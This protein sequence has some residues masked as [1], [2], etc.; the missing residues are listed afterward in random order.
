MIKEITAIKL[1]KWL[2]N[3]TILAPILLDVREPFEFEIAKIEGSKLMSMNSV[4][5]NIDKLSNK[6]TIVCICHHGARSLQVANYLLKNGV[7]NIF[8]L[9]GGIEAWSLEVDA[10]LTRY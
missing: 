6:A 3:K 1:K 8:N 7:T 9:S 2:D 10:S 4:P 5:D